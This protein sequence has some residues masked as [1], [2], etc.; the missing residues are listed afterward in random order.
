[1]TRQTNEC[2]RGS[3]VQRE[4]YAACRTAAT[5]RNQRRTWFQLALFWQASS[6]ASRA[7]ILRTRRLSAEA[8]S[9][10]ADPHEPPADE[11]NLQHR[12]GISSSHSA[13]PLSLR[14]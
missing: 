14:P 10:K 13:P 12:D 1:M 8:R 11:P 7:S 3:V 5:W 6:S 2:N 9:A 4:D